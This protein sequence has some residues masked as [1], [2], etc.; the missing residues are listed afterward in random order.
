MLNGR[1][2]Q[3][4]GEAARVP[5]PHNLRVLQCSSAGATGAIIL[6]AWLARGTHPRVIVK[7]PRDPR[8][9]HAL[10]REWDA[11]NLVRK[12]AALARAVPAAIQKLAL[13]GTDYY[14]YEGVPGRT[15][16]SCFRNRLLVSSTRLRDTSAAQALEASV[17]VHQTHSRQAGPDEVAEDL[18]VDLA[19]LQATVA[20]FPEDIYRHAR[21][22]AETLASSGRAL[23]YGRVHGDLSPY[24][25]MVR[26]DAPGAIARLIDWEHFEV[27]RPQHLDVFRFISAYGL[28]GAKADGRKAAIQAMSAMT[29]PLIARLLRPWL[30][31][32]GATAAFATDARLLAALWWHYRIHAA[33]RE[34]ERLARHAD[35]QE[36]TFLR[37][38]TAF[39]AGC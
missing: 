26:T 38:L 28:M 6:H 25:L 20:S 35:H 19:W 16:D 39:A 37:G 4:I 12:N 1:L 32:M 21:A 14:I 7:T 33:R 34:Q 2:R 31:R 13:D 36:P 15:M 27:E 22:A 10:S 11:V 8:L 29:N 3:A 24:N 18:L 30:D 5:D 23:P 9:P 17:L